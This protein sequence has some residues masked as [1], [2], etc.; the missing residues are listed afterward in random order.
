MSSNKDQPNILKQLGRL[1]KPYWQSEKKREAWLVLLFVITFVILLVAINAYKTYLTRDVMNAL[2]AHNA[3]LFWKTIGIA[4]LALG[5]SVPI[6]AFKLYSQ[7]YF[8][9]RWRDWLNRR[10]LDRY[11]DKDTYYA[12]NLYSD[13]DNPDQ[14]LA[15]DLDAFVS[16]TVMFFGL[17]LFAL[18]ELI[19]MTGV[20]LSISWKLVACVIVYAIIGTTI[21]VGLSRRLV[22]LNFENIRYQADYRYGLV[23]VRNNVESIAFYR[24]EKREAQGLKKRF[25]DLMD[26]FRDLITLERNISFFKEGYGLYGALFPFIILLQPYLAGE[27]AIG[28]ITQSVTVFGLMLKDLSLIVNNFNDL[29][30]YAASIRRLDGFVEALDVEPPPSEKVSIQAD[31]KLALSKV[32]VQTPDLSKTLVKDLDLELAEGDGVLIMGPSGCGKSSLLR[33]IAGLWKAGSGTI[34]KPD[35]ESVMFLPQRP[36]LIIGTLREQLMYPQ[37]DK[38]LPDEKLHWALGLVNLGDLPERVGGMDCVMPWADMLSLGEQQRLTFARLL[39]CAPTYAILDE[40]TSALDE[41]NEQ[42]LYNLLREHKCTFLSVGHRSSLV[43]YH[44]YIL[45]MEPPHGWELVPTGSEKG[46]S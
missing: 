29:S 11:F 30:T 2:E 7:R 41:P 23:H 13:I 6:V 21:M 32:T 4:A 10:L 42:T 15:A 26:N 43:N 18:L 28:T 38:D 37:L 1:I 31:D 40:S 25:T 39:L 36:Y 44:D 35:L 22:K 46:E 45:R 27:I 3:E 24:G 14:R 19:T 12:I 9:Y 16:K 34:H 33:G 20:L 8:T 17:A 5:V